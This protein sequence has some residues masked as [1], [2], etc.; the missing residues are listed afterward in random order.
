MSTRYYW[1][2]VFLLFTNYSIILYTFQ[3]FRSPV[4]LK[5]HVQNTHIKTPHTCPTCSVELSSIDKLKKHI[6]HVHNS[7]YVECEICSKKLKKSNLRSHKRKSHMIKQS[8]HSTSF[9]LSLFLIK[10]FHFFYLSF[11]IFMHILSANIQI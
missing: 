2:F 11:S 4:Y 6:R 5:R 8:I 9:W 10:I 1:N 7:P 3:V